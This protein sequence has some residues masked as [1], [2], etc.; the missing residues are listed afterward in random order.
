MIQVAFRTK[1]SPVSRID[2]RVVL[3][4]NTLLYIDRS[5]SYV[6]LKVSR[7]TL[8]VHLKINRFF[9]GPYLRAHLMD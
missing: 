8:L 6:S 3:V 7:S 4:R 1:R 9:N 2:V 5:R